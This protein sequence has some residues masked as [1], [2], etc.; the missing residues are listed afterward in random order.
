[1]ACSGI[2]TIDSID[3]QIPLC[4]FT[5]MIQANITRILKDI[6]RVCKQ[7]GRNPEEIILVGVSKFANAVNIREAIDLGLK[8]IGEN[9]VQQAQDKFPLLKESGFKVTKH[10]I[11]HLQTNKVKPA[12]E[13]FDFIESVDSIRLADAIEKQAVKLNKTVD[14]LLQVNTAGEQQKFGCDPK[15][16]FNLVNQ[17]S[18]L[19][20]VHLYGLMTIAP[21]LEDKTLVR[22]CF[23]DLKVLRDQVA[24]QFFQ[25]KNIEMKYLS[26]GMSEDYAIAIEEGS[27]MIRIGRAIFGEI[28]LPP[29]KNGAKG[30]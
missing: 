21:R 28:D 24:Q 9:K 3:Y 26:M 8:H 16:V 11:G 6:K 7:V 1:M 22:Q 4:Y 20:H 5:R 13:V 30:I 18:S 25:A 2:H 29:L 23:R 14:I 27:N 15:D 19:K 10:M 17:I 12:L